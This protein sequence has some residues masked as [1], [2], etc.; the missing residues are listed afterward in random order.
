M[1]FTHIFSYLEKI[2]FSRILILNGTGLY[3]AAQFCTNIGCLKQHSNMSNILINLLIILDVFFTK[4]QISSHC[5]RI[6]S[7]RYGRNDVPRN[8]RYCN[9]C[10]TFHIEDLYHFVIVCPGNTTIYLAHICGCN[11]YSVN[12]NYTETT[13]RI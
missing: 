3:N 11:P 4:Y 9:C 7:G 8:E 2:L 1:I 13:L 6:K 5:L 12:Q 10:N